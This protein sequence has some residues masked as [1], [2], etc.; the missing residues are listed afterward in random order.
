MFKQYSLL[1]PVRE[2][3]NQIAIDF[4]GISF[5]PEKELKLFGEL[6]Q[7]VEE[8]SKEWTIRYRPNTARLPIGERTYRSKDL[9]VLEGNFMQVIETNRNDPGINN[10][11]GIIN[12]P[13]MAIGPVEDWPDDFIGI[14]GSG[15]KD[16]AD[17]IIGMRNIYSKIYPEP[18]DKIGPKSIFQAY[19]LSDFERYSKPVKK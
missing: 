9:R 14:V 12:V 13:D 7:S 8:G 16:K 17:M 10:L 2:L 19:R 18:K 1:V 6:I 5:H 15:F 11:A 3:Q 4:S